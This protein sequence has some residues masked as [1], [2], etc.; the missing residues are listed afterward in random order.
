MKSIASIYDIKN[1][2]I[3][4]SF[5][6]DKK[7]LKK[8]IKT[9]LALNKIN[10]L[11]SDKIYI[12]YLCE[13]KQ[14]QIIIHSFAFTNCVFELFKLNAS[15][16]NKEYSFDLFVCKDFFVVYKNN[17]FYCYQELNQEFTIDELSNYIRNTFKI[18]I[19]NIFN[20]NNEKL[21]YLKKEFLQINQESEL[22]NLNK[23]TRVSFYVYIIYLILII[24]SLYIYIQY[25]NY[26]INKN[27]TT[28]IT[29]N[30]YEYEKTLN[31]LKYKPFYKNYESIIS[32]IKKY[33]LKLTSMSYENKILKLSVST[34][35][36]EK[37][38]SFLNLY[39]N[40]ISSNFISF[41]KSKKV[42]KCVADVEIYR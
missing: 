30:N 11:S 24:G 8:F 38:F 35:S 4:V 32:N 31:S 34:T 26:E 19:I 29:E 14:Y 10:Y 6:I 37:L 21:D 3:P 41:D 27:N 16:I 36:K 7:S 12:S 40:Q 20:I 28:A 17:I 5:E 18:N 9:S 39:K 13:S 42:Y 22:I 23:N 1:L 2:F 25:K 15:S 33:K